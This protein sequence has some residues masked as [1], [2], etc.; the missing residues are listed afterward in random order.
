ML[1]KIFLAVILSLSVSCFAESGGS[2][3]KSLIDTNQ[4]SQSSADTNQQSQSSQSDSL[5]KKRERANFSLTSHKKRCTLRLC[6][7]LRHP[8][9]SI[10]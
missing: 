7:C 8:A 2:R 3:S 6:L 9:K 5:I 1:K 10:Y 4:Q